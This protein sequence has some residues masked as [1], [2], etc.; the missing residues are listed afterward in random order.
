MISKRNDCEQEF[1]EICEKQSLLYDRAIDIANR[2]HAGPASAAAASTGLIDLQQ[3]LDEVAKWGGPVNE[4]QQRWEALGVSAG[5]QLKQATETL[6]CRV[7]QLLLLI[8]Q[9]ESRFQAAREQLRPRV[10]MQVTAK[11]MV[12]AYGERSQ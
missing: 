1:C 7:E 8:N 5:Q 3:A 9:A 4:A 11:R 12:D 10:D 2:I 6:R